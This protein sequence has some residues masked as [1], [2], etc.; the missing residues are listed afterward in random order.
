VPA[1]DRL[2]ELERLLGRLE[3]QTLPPE[4]FEVI[5]ADDGS[6]GSLEGLRAR[7]PRT[8]FAPGPPHNSYA[9]RNRGARAARA[10]VLA[11]CDSDCEPAPDWLEAGL[12]AVEHAELAAGRVRRLSRRAPTVWTLLDVDKFL[13]QERWARAGRAVTA[14]L[15]VRRETFEALGGF[16]EG[17]A[18]G[19]DFD[20][21][22]RCVRA[23]ARLTF[24]SDAVVDHPTLDG[25]RPFLA[26]TWRVQAR[27]TPL[28]PALRD[29]V[30]FVARIRRG[31]P[32][33]LDTARLGE[34][35]LQAGTRQRMAALVLLSWMLPCLEFAAQLSGWL[36]ARR[37]RPG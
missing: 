2:D 36:R 18:S 32:L 22:E 12:A 26:K 31:R 8:R 27:R 35:G 14:N 5:V 10:P 21:V 17:F 28:R 3:R 33:G 29:L 1:R 4:A 23:G 30:P 6:R 7:H 34:E 16:A 9:A 19:G 15:L 13:D 37:A 20:F 25:A 11:F 24:A